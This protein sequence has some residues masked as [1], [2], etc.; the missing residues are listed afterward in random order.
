MTATTARPF[1]YTA[2]GQKFFPFDP[3]PIM[4]DL[5]DMAYGLANKA[6][7]SGQTREFYSVAAHSVRVADL[8]K[9]WTVRPVVVL[10]ALLHD[11]HEA[12]LADIPT[13]LK[14]FMRLE[15][16]RTWRDVER[17]IQGAIHAKVGIGIEEISA[18]EAALIKKAD[19]IL[20]QIEVE[21]LFDKPT[22]AKFRKS[23]RGMPLVVKANRHAAGDRHRASWGFEDR[24]SDLLPNPKK[25]LRRLDTKEDSHG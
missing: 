22:A 25:G 9:S 7:F 11:A 4:I 20:L 6:R 8:V 18:K 3:K 12:Y 1:I 21:E 5:E 10:A 19:R 15:D 16:D 23:L 24:L 13:P 2:T 17:G 14:P